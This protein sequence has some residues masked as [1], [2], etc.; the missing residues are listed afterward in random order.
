MYGYDT[1]LDKRYDR[2]EEVMGLSGDGNALAMLIHYAGY[3]NE[4][5]DWLEREYDIEEEDDDEEDED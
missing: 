4:V 5:F 1:T 2:I 3:S